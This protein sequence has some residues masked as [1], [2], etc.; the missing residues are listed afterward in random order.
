MLVAS[1]SLM[2][3]PFL[4]GFFSKELVLNVVLLS[5]GVVGKF[6]YLCGLFTT[7]LTAVYSVRLLFF[8]F[9]CKPRNSRKKL[10]NFVSTPVYLRKYMY[11]LACGSVFS[12]YLGNDIFVGAGRHIFQNNVSGVY[13]G[14]PV[15]SAECLP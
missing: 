5:G 14:V 11:L 4:S 1:L 7:V 13:G 15:I 10:A 6:S 9:F 3:V 2:G 8:V 12:G